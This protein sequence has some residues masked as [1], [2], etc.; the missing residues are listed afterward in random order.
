M[1]LA[2][3]A[4]ASWPLVIGASG[5]PPPGEISSGRR[6]PAPLTLSAAVAQAR[7]ASP[8][9][10]AA[11]LIA[12][13][14]RDAVRFAGRPPNPLFEFR[15]ENWARSSRASSPDLDVFALVTQPVELGGKRAVRRELARSDSL[16]ARAA[17][18]SLDRDLALETVHAYVRALKARGLVETLA[19]N[20]DGLTLLVATV[21]RRVGEGYTAESDLLKFKTEA[22]RIDGDIA[23][24]QLELERSIAALAIIIGEPAAIDAAQLA[25]P[26]ALAVP[27]D[28]SPRLAVRLE[29]HPDVLAA[30]AAI[31]RA[32]QQTLLERALRLPD[33]L[34]TGGYKRTAGVDTAVLGVSVTLP[35]FERNDSALARAMGIERAAVADRD[36]LIHRLTLEAVS[37]IRSAQ[38]IAERAGRVTEDLLEPAEQ[39]RR[40]ARAAFRE[41]TADVLKLIDAER[42][43]AD[44]QRAAIELRLDALLTTIEARFALGEE[45]IP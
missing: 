36:A 13:A 16:V 8:R 17:A 14:M 45:T 39:V 31:E 10:R 9:R 5:P 42:V 29:R 21:A 33:P 20:R 3:V 7:A 43:Y 44:V 24:A 25:E 35:L 28:V 30:T 32:R 40:A 37:V 4:F 18:N 15:T 12:E 19:A 26:P 2:L 23:R 22:A 6:P 41:G 11:V 38:M 1:V 34:I 27:S